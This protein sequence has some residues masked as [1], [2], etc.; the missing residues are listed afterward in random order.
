MYTYCPECH[1]GNLEHRTTCQCCGHQLAEP[2]EMPTATAT[3]ADYHGIMGLGGIGAYTE[4]EIP[5]IPN[6]AALERIERME[7]TDIVCRRCGASQNFDGAMFT[8]DRN[9]GICDDCYG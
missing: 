8:A 3:S 9:S 1:F 6:E 2:A 5:I 4:N 7:R